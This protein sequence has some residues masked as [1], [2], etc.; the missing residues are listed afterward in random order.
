MQR[1]CL[2]AI[3]EVI[4]ALRNSAKINVYTVE[5]PDSM[6]LNYLLTKH[7]ASLKDLVIG[8]EL[9][10]EIPVGSKFRINMDSHEIEI[11]FSE[12][13]QGYPTYL[14]GC[15]NVDIIDNLMADFA[16]VVGDPFPDPCP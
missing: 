14:V 5:I 4:R 3:G 6:F 9:T 16:E 8:K 12:S 2:I 15:C 1:D 13:A 10:Y 7:R 11:M